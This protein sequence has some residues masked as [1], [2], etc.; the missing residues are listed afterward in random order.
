M[1]SI[2]VGTISAI[3]FVI[4]V[5][6]MIFGIH[7]LAW[8]HCRPCKHCGTFLDYRGAI[9]NNDDDLLMFQCPKCGS[10]EVISKQEFFRDCE[11]ADY[12]PNNLWQ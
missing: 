12:N 11:K 3:V 2:L 6:A 8:F 4:V 9:E 1:L 7:Y 10:K 5:A